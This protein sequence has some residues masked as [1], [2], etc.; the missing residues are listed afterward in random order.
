MHDAGVGFR[1]DRLL[2]LGDRVLEIASPEQREREAAQDLRVV[3][4]MSEVAA[5]VNGGMIEP[6]RPQQ[7]VSQMMLGLDVGFS[8]R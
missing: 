6:L 7:F 1:C 4:T 3:R 2:Q 5:V 8:G